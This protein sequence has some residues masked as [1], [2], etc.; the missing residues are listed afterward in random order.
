MDRMWLG[1][2]WLV[3]LQSW[4]VVN[5]LRKRTGR[6]ERVL[7][8]Y[9]GDLLTA[10]LVF[11]GFTLLVPAIWQGLDFS[12]IDRGLLI[13]EDILIGLM[14]VFGL[15]LV[16]SLTPWDSGYPSD[17]VAGAKEIFG[18][19]TKYFPGNLREYAVFVV[20]IVVGVVFEEFF[21]RQFAFQLFYEVLGVEG[22]GLVLLTAGLFAIG[23]WYQGFRGVLTSLVLGLILG[24]V[25]LHYGDLRYPLV[26]H[27]CLNLTILVYAFRRMRTLQA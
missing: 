26:L 2:V 25:Y 18:F 24:K 22:D 1:L 14:S 9:A 8:F 6:P 20:F 27:L 17:D 7:R 11:G 16:M 19:P 12:G 15:P 10:G 3:A 13:R 23:H 21:S 4:F 5:G